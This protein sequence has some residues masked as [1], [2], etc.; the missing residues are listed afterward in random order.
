MTQTFN[1]VMAALAEL[2]RGSGS[3]EKRAP[4]AEADEAPNEHRTTDASNDSAPPAA[5]PHRLPLLRPSVENI[6]AELRELKRW[7]PWRAQWNEK[8]GKWDK[9][10]CTPSGTGLSTN[11]PERWLPF[12]AALKAYTA[13]PDH[14][15]GVGLVM[16]GA[17]GLVG[18]DLD[19]CVSHE[20]GVADWAQE[21]VVQAASYTELSPS[22]H[23]LRIFLNGA[24]TRDWTNH[25]RGIEV[26]AGHAPRFLTVTGEALPQRERVCPAP[27]GWLDDLAQRYAPPPVE[28]PA[29][30]DMPE[31]VDELALPDLAE[32]GM[33]APAAAFLDSGEHR[34]D[35]S[36]ELFAAAVALFSAGLEPREVL[37]V[38]AHNPH[39]MEVA[40]DHRRQDH[41]RALHYLWR[42]HVQKAQARATS[43]VASL[44]DFDDVSASVPPPTGHAWTRF[45]E[46]RATPQ[47]PRFVIPWF[48]Q[49]GVVVI[50]GAP[51]VGKTT[52]LLPL[53][54]TA[55]G[56]HRAGDPLAPEHWRHICY[57]TEA[58][59]QVEQMLAAAARCPELGVSFEQI[60]ERVHVAPLHRMAPAEAVK[61]GGFFAANFT[62]RV[63][64]TVVP[65]LV[66][67]D[68]QAAALALENENANSEVSA[69]VAAFK[70]RFAGLPVWF[71][72]HTAKT[73]W[74]NSDAKA[75]T[76]RGGGAWGGDA[77]QLLFVVEDCGRS[78]LR[79]SKTRFEA[80]WP[81]LEITTDVLNV[82]MLH[83]DGTAA[84]HPVRWASLAP[85]G[86][87]Q[88]A[89]DRKDDTL[90]IA[91][92]LVAEQHE[93]GNPV[94]TA[95]GGPKNS[96]LRLRSLSK[97]IERMRPGAVH[98]L[99]AEAEARGLLTQ[100]QHRTAG[101]RDG[102]VWVVTEAGRA[103]LEA[104]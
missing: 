44:D 58:P 21:V 78:Y 79:R 49:E 45:L 57:L 100:E 38:L 32:L 8:R 59:E 99:L 55:A 51:G 17:E 9:I 52:T 82:P 61:A 94:S 80:R 2:E 73:Q 86:A 96:G 104:L 56:L 53:A 28:K 35:R 33:P 47:A 41:E 71:V 89:A 64:E 16:T 95:V 14:F 97:T 12:D 76:A 3:Q 101:G 42:E 5:Q 74:E 87:A 81:E 103:W 66:V 63:G 72:S 27:A 62:R 92:G 69:A 4:T 7:A 24:T 13:R 26:Y 43:K 75:L 20:G 54:L 68:T 46:L 23:G 15:A 65:P 18:I 22:G 67:I 19:G 83:A 40:L 10:P 36:G 34:G 29:E 88:G 90:R 25:G 70:Q 77:H 98:D 91:L 39:A 48:I 50:A 1:D 102:A 30:A 85:V 60:A 37:S 6:P 11:Q 84:E 31:L 93:A